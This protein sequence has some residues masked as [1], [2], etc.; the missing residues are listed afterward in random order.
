MSAL[1]TMVGGTHYQATGGIQPIQFFNANPQLSFPACNVIKYIY[2][3][4]EK[5]GLEDLL[6][7]IHYTLFEAEF[8]Y[9][10]EEVDQFKANIS[11]L[12]EG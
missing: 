12:I 1:N 2:R 7:V 5:K 11:K 6:K 9:A 10:K 8:N 4:K 3:H